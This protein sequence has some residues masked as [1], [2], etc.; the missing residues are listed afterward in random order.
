MELWGSNGRERYADDA[1]VRARP[2]GLF[3][4][5]GIIGEVHRRYHLPITITEAH[6]G[7][8][9]EEEQIRW[10]AE[11]WNGAHNA[12]AKG[13][14][15]QAVTAWSLLGSYDWNTLAVQ[16]NGH[17][18]R[19]AFEVMPD[20]SLQATRLAEFLKQAAQAGTIINSEMLGK[21]WWREP[22]RLRF[23]A[24]PEPALQLVA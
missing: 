10:F 2:E 13:A 14:D 6:L 23:P 24:E 12:R 9:Q 20:G 5:E 7:C 18:E 21:G 19:G 3:G 17:Y 22:S 4:I 1:A 8:A 16:A 11:I 15:V